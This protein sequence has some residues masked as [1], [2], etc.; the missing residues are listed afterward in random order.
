LPSRALALA[1]ASF[2]VVGLGALAAACSSSSDAASATDAESRTDAGIDAAAVTAYGGPS[3]LSTCPVDAPTAGA[4]CPTQGAQCEYGEAFNPSCNT[5]ATCLGDTTVGLHWSVQAP[6]PPPPLGACP[7]PGAFTCPASQPAAGSACTVRG[8]ICTFDKVVCSC[9]G[10]AEAGVG[11]GSLAWGCESTSC[12]LPRPR[13]GCG[14]TAA[15]ECHFGACFGFSAY[16]ASLSCT[17][18]T[19]AW[20]T[21]ACSDAAI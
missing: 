12:A 7:A 10:A 6:S 11:S 14:C 1:V 15:A 3:C 19:G 5:I 18:A 4:A 16:G 2:G 8:A 20:S 13:I 21:T 17:A 9:G